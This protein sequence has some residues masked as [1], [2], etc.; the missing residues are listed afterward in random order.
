[1]GVAALQDSGKVLS[2]ESLQIAY[3]G[4]ALPPSRPVHW[5]LSV[6][7]AKGAA[8]ACSTAAGSFEPALQ[9]GEAGWE[10]AEWLARFPPA[11]LNVSGCDLYQVGC[12]LIGPHSAAPRTRPHATACVVSWWRSKLTAAALIGDR[13][14]RR[15]SLPRQGECG[16][17][18]RAGSQPPHFAFTLKSPPVR[19]QVSVPA[20]IVSARA[21]IAGLGYA[22]LYINGQRIG[23]GRL[24]PGW[25]SYDKTVLYVVH[26]VTKELSSAGA[27]AT[28]GLELGN[29]WWNPLT[30]KFWGR[31]HN[32]PCCHSA[33]THCFSYP[34]SCSFASVWT[35]KRVLAEH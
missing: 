18:E 13:S 10:G 6:W 7:G 32:Q 26:D 24:D 35:Q 28:V 23:T 22:T 33:A 3:E 14:Q 8:D 27:E 16:G 9:E 20:A 5:R 2:S 25:T 21:Y 11:P 17:G 19:R 4:K 15:P 29:G 1:M 12:V 34:H 30:L 31:V